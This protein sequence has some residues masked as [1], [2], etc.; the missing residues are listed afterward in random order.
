VVQLHVIS[1][2][3]RALS[4]FLADESFALHQFISHLVVPFALLSTIGN[5]NFTVAAPQN[6]NSLP[7]SVTDASSFERFKQQL[8]TFLLSL[9][10]HYFSV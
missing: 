7:E 2:R 6:W 5:R 9:F 4:T 10:C 3:Q 1:K 8:K